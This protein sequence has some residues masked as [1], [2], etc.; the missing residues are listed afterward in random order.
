MELWG[1]TR[2]FVI[3]ISIFLISFARAI[4]RPIFGGQYKPLYNHV[5]EQMEPQC[6][7][8]YGTTFTIVY[9]TLGSVIFYFGIAIFIFV[10][11][12]RI[13][14]ALSSEKFREMSKTNPSI[15]AQRRNVVHM[16]FA[17]VIA[18]AL[19]WV[20]G[21]TVN[22]TYVIKD[23]QSFS[24]S[25]WFTVYLF[26]ARV[27]L[28]GSCAFNP[29]IYIRMSSSFRDTVAKRLDGWRAHHSSVSEKYVIN[30]SSSTTA[31]SSSTEKA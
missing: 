12:L 4:I 30:S 28:Y 24:N 10:L 29:L 17:I 25:N 26:I 19:L 9:H 16:L 18:F 2:C 13:K 5:S 21:Y 15:M 8:D 27:L 14:K 3:C 7:E 23:H 1:K 22:L 6:A 20:M 31:L 11:N